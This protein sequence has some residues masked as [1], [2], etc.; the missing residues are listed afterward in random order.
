M[1]NKDIVS[2][3]REF[4]RFYV[5]KMNLLGNHYLGSEYSVTEARVF[6]KYMK[7]KG[8]MQHILRK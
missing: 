6:L 5:P 4:N 3:V 1:D 8:V 7:I 2:K